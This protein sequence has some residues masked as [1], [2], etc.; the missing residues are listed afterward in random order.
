MAVNLEKELR[1]Y[2]SKYWDAVNAVTSLTEEK[3]QLEARIAELEKDFK[4]MDCI[5]IGHEALIHD[6]QKEKG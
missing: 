3:Q 2:R 4:D 1:E 5:R 6:L